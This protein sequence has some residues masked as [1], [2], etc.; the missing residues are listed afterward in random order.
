MDA[1]VI[2]TLIG[3]EFL[4]VFGHK[5]CDQLMSARVL[6]QASWLTMYCLLSCQLRWTLLLA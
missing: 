1:Q 4:F 3:F 5:E 6:R 2:F